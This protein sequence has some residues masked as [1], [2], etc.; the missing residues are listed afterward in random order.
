MVTIHRSAPDEVNGQREKGYTV[1]MADTRNAT[2]FCRK[3]PIWRQIA[4]VSDPEVDY[5]LKE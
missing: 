5:A 3:I 4:L 1:G 2:F